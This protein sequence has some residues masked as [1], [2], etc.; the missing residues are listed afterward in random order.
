MKLN[1]IIALAL[2][3][4]MTSALL[5]GCGQSK[6]SSEALNI[7]NVGDYIDEELIKKF[8]AETGITV[9]YE[10]YDTNESMYQKLKSGSTKYDLIFPSDYMVEK[11]VSEDMVSEID[12]KNIPNYKYIMKDF[13]DPAYDP[14]N[15]HSVPYMWG[16]FGIIYN[17]TMVDEKDVDSW[18]VLWNPKYKGEIQMLDSVRDTMGIALMKLGYLINTEKTSEIEAAKKELIKQLPL[19]QAYVND[20]G[21]DRLIVGDAAMGIV[22]NGDAL[23]LMDENPD[24]AYSIPKEGTNQWIDAISIPKISENKDYAEM[25]INFMLEPENALQNV[26]YIEYSTPHEKAYEM[27]DEEVK[28][29][30]TSYPSEEILD[31]SDVFLNLPKDVLKKYEDAWTEIKSQ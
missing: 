23:V 9:V 28:N 7:Y 12:Y 6:K 8:E 16:T 11:L 3:V 31:K 22:Y 25:F 19:V 26:E 24:L 21:K 2:T 15:K 18:D 13:K 5:V 1:K 4:M 29:D 14:G 20:D 10:T 27:L 30:P 17:K